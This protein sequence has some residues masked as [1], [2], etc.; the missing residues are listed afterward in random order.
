MWIIIIQFVVSRQYARYTQVSV[1]RISIAGVAHQTAVRCGHLSR[2]LT[3]W[4]RSGSYNLYLSWS[5]LVIRLGLCWKYV[6][7]LFFMISLEF[8]R[9]FIYVLPVFHCFLFSLKFE[10]VPV[11]FPTVGCHKVGNSSCFSCVFLFFL[12]KKRNIIE[13]KIIRWWMP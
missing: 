6:S 2:D 11:F 3:P 7:V 12:N 4:A 10:C 1:H 5:I 8:Y 13:K 9:A